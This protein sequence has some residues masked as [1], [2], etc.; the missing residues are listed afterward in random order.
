VPVT[1]Q[2][3]AAV[4]SR[5][6]LPDGRVLAF[7]GAQVVGFNLFEAQWHA[8]R[9]A[10]TR[11]HA[12][13]NLHRRDDGTWE[14][15]DPT[16]ELDVARDLG[17]AVLLSYA[18]LEGLGNRTIEEMR[19]DA[20]V[21]FERDGETITLGRDQMERVLSVPEKLSV[22]VPAFTRKPSI[23]GGALWGKL[24]R[25]CSLRDGLVGGASHRVA[26]DAEILGRLY[27][28]DADTCAEDAIAVVGALRPEFLPSI[29][30]DASTSG[31]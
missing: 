30:L 10:R 4:V 2:D 19:K 29:L 9:G 3:N 18:G 16:E 6:E 13:G 23:E 15:S 22:V 7:R 12:V 11:R 17:A 31:S 21:E 28:G 8:R 20:T 14:I 5:V 1:S 24:E 25:I 27:R 26:Q